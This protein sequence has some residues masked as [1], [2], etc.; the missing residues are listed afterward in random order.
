MMAAAAWLFVFHLGD[1]PYWLDQSVSFRLVWLY[2]AVFL[3]L[4]KDIYSMARGT[5][6]S[7]P[8]LTKTQ[9]VLALLFAASCLSSGGLHERGWG[10]WPLLYWLALARVALA[11][12]QIFK[13]EEAVDSFLRWSAIVSTAFA[14]LLLVNWVWPNP[15]LPLLNK[16]NEITN[17]NIFAQ[18]CGLLILACA[19]SLSVP[20]TRYSKIVVL[21]TLAVLFFFLAQT[22]VRASLLATLVTLAVWFDV[23]KGRR[24]G[25][26]TGVVT[27]TIVVYFAVHLL[28]WQNHP[29]S[30]PPTEGAAT[31]AQSKIN[32]IF[33][34]Q[35]K[36]INSL[37]M[38]WE[39]PLGIGSW[40]FEFYYP[41][42]ATRFV[43]DPEL[44]SG[45]SLRSAHNEVLTQFVELGWLGGIAFIGGVLLL[46]GQA[47][48]SLRK[49]P[50]D[51]RARLG[52]ALL[53]YLVVE[54]LVAFVFEVPIPAF[55]AAIATGA[56]LAMCEHRKITLPRLAIPIWGCVCAYALLLC[57][58]IFEYDVAW[59]HRRGMRYGCGILKAN[60]PSCLQKAQN[61]MIDGEVEKGIAILER[62]KKENSRNRQVRDLLVQMKLV[63]R[64]HAE[65][66][67]EVGELEALLARRS[68][69]TGICNKN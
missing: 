18:Q 37:H 20:A 64:D 40:N 60:W 19:M 15:T 44:K 33:L 48:R 47:N 11:V 67:R 62:M 23:K 10:F 43:A 61:H 4:L 68:S 6:L 14:C 21:V 50:A 25:P 52:L 39:H 46:F 56:C 57:V 38:A 51:K 16:A 30:S 55:Y 63:G 65:A 17:S 24:I 31:F 2:L 41:E 69:F 49:N 5:P 53:S 3:L 66:C 35:I 58:S 59:M 12:S 13:E 22:G 29:L 8:R 1:G 32:S 36:W 42:Y 9:S 28:W 27:M 26:I 54:G 34:R 7:V 45:Q